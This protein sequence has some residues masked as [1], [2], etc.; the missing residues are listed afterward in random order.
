MSAAI[1]ARH[2]ATNLVTLQRMI[3]EPFIQTIGSNMVGIKNTNWNGQQ[4]YSA[5]S[6]IQVDPINI[7]FNQTI[8]ATS[9][10][11]GLGVRLHWKG[12]F[13]GYMIPGDIDWEVNEPNIRVCVAASGLQSLQR[14]THHAP[15]AGDNERIVRVDVMSDNL[16]VCTDDGLTEHVIIHTSIYDV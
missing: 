14:D 15:V 12:I 6:E 11:Y 5:Y 8:D 9:F 13:K 3:S 4:R 10:L 2:A 16:K 1:I 7:P